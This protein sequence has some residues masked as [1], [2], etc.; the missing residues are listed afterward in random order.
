[1]SSIEQILNLFTNSK[2]DSK[3]LQ[4]NKELIEI[5]QK[6]VEKDPEARFSQILSNFGFVSQIDGNWK[7]E[8]YT[9]PTVVLER[10]KDR[11]TKYGI[12]V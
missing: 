4:A 8:F 9:E 7:D 11:L 3:R 2:K 12:K 5:F 6:L 1:M 10:V